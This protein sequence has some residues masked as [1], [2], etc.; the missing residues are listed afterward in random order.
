MIY[1]MI[2]ICFSS[3]PTHQCLGAI[4]FVAGDWLFA[5][6]TCKAALILVN[7]SDTHHLPHVWKSQNHL[8][9]FHSEMEGNY[10]MG[11][12]DVTTTSYFK[13]RCSKTKGKRERDGDQQSSVS[14]T[15]LNERQI[16]MMM[17]I[18]HSIIIRPAGFHV[19]LS[20]YSPAI[21]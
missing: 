9:L 7:P 10:K 19:D 16:M 4:T 6:P 12:N 1:R 5:T 18:A 11:W 14:I 20:S 3:P 8:I 15:T 13:F 21:Q 2:Y 17:M